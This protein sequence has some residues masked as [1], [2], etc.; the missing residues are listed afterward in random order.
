MATGKSDAARAWPGRVRFD[1]WSRTLAGRR[2]KGRLPS[3]HL[4]TAVPALDSQVGLVSLSTAWAAASKVTISRA[5][6]AEAQ[7]EPGKKS[8]AT[9]LK[10]RG[11]G[12]L[13]RNST[14][15]E[16][17]MPT[18]VPTAPH[19]SRGFVRCGRPR[20]WATLEQR[21]GAKLLERSAQR[22]T[23]NGPKTAR[24]RKTSWCGAGR[25]RIPQFDAN[26][27]ARRGNGRATTRRKGSLR[28]VP[29]RGSE[30]RASCCAGSHFG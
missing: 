23:T 17:R 13:T 11:A 29:K 19:H 1:R 3:P 28:R 27:T 10:V 8:P 18:S 15:P 12:R 6:A 25:A 7:W 20:Q 2:L 4:G 22:R 16:R 30:P 5:Q 24:H 21:S 26:P 14:G 9:S